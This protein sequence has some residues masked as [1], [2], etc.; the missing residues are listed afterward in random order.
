MDSCSDTTLGSSCNPS[1][2]SDTF[3]GTPRS[4]LSMALRITISGVSQRP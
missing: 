4:L 1:V 2:N 3:C